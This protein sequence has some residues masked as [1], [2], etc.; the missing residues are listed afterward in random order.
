MARTLT[1]SSY[2]KVLQISNTLKCVA[3]VIAEGGDIREELVYNMLLQLIKETD[4]A[5]RQIEKDIER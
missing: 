3:E 5:M 2:K 4:K 1:V